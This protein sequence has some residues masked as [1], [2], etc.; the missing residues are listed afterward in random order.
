MCH[1]PSWT[2]EKLKKGGQTL[3]SSQFSHQHLTVQVIAADFRHK[4]LNSPGCRLCWRLPAAC[5]AQWRAF[6][7]PCWLHGWA[8]ESCT[9]RLWPRTWRPAVTA[10]QRA[11]FTHA[12]RSPNTPQPRPRCSLAALCLENLSRT[13]LKEA[14]ACSRR[15]TRPDSLKYFPAQIPSSSGESTSSD[16]AD[17]SNTLDAIFWGNK[18]ATEQI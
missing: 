7:S 14:A 17:S 3:D 11:S 12:T 15:P 1:L 10:Q 4:R 9:L 18:R 8:A 13:M 5:R 6:W 16:T 2:L